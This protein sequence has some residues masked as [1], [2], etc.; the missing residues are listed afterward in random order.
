[1]MVDEKKIH[2]KAD[3]I[4][5]NAGILD[6]TG[7]FYT[8]KTLVIHK[9]DITA[10]VDAGE[11]KGVDETGAEVVDCSQL[12]ITP[13][14]VNLHTHSPMTLFRGLAED[15]SID[16]WFNREIWPYEKNLQA[17]HV[18][19]GALAAIYEMIN[20]G[21]TAFADHYMFPEAIMQAVMESPIR[22]DLAPTLFGL[23]DTIE[24]EMEACRSLI[25][26][27]QHTNSRLA[28]RVG[29]H[30]PYTCPPP[31]LKTMVAMAKELNT[32]IHLHVSETAAQVKESL[33]VYGKTPFQMVAEAGGF[34][35]PVIIAHGLWIM[36]EDRLLLSEATTI[37]V[38]PK[39]YLKLAMGHGHLWDDSM[40][41]PLASGTDG[42]A[43]SNTL[44][45]LEQV[46]LFG[47]LGKHFHQDATHFGCQTL[48]KILMRGH[49]ALPFQS[50][51]IAVGAAADLTLWQLTQPG[52]APVHHP[53][54][55]ILYSS[56]PQQVAHVMVEGK[57]AKK[58]GRVN[59]NHHHV[60][61]MLTEASNHLMTL[62]KGSIPF[63][64]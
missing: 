47:L 9:G 34:D 15:V 27:H 37:A 36:P 49:E 30:A 52:V 5:K 7:T 44:D 57:W 18:H 12:V 19:A 1:M 26:E 48:W 28:L 58:D 16:D 29:P 40:S 10:I 3:V 60:K 8:A 39:T 2:V 41:L 62:G 50:G 42:A 4:L 20:C 31:V 59:M 17:S 14:L 53:L 6:E 63:T 56:G 45:P 35:V 11:M 21:V 33:K 55:A 22:C 51:K 64:F 13:G 32:G 46:R 24:T 61:N 54:A 23:S 43:S 25:K 38:S